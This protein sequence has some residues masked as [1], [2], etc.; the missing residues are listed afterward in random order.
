M[1]IN[2]LGDKTFG[3]DCVGFIKN[4]NTVSRLASVH[5]NKS[6]FKYAGPPCIASLLLHTFS[7]FASDRI[8]QKKNKKI[9]V[10]RPRA[11]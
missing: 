11:V 3:P 6:D 1:R 10:P 8:C 9:T 4:S 2:V 7:S 5:D